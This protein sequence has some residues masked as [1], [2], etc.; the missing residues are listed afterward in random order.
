MKSAIA[1][2]LCSC[3]VFNAEAQG[4]REG[5]LDVFTDGTNTAFRVVIPD[6]DS[7]LRKFGGFAVGYHLLIDVGGDELATPLLLPEVDVPSP[8]MM[9]LSYVVN[10]VWPEGTQ[11]AAYLYDRD[12]N[13]LDDAAAGFCVLH[14]HNSAARAYVE[15]KPREDTIRADMEAAWDASRADTRLFSL[16]QSHEHN[17]NKRK[18]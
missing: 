15:D 2:I 11:F 13:M 6:P 4:G 8:G 7:E 18:D 9:T 16:E 3:L 5:K 10:R 12:G 17:A 1:F 14:F